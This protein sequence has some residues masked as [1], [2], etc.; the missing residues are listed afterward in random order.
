MGH[1]AIVYLLDQ[2]FECLVL[3]TAAIVVKVKVKELNVFLHF[4]LI[5]VAHV[6]R[7]D[8]DFAW[9]LESEQVDAV[10]WPICVKDLLEVE[11]ESLSSS[12]QGFWSGRRLPSSLVAPRRQG[13]SL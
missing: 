1:N 11:T 13:L 4:A 3:I 7:R 6:L 12:F 5:D 8:Q 10:D 2:N 9:R